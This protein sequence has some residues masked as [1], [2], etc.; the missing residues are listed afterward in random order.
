MFRTIF[1]RNHGQRQS[2]YQGSMNRRNA[3]PVRPLV[4]RLDPSWGYSNGYQTGY[5]P[6]F[7]R[8]IVDTMYDN[9]AEKP[10][11]NPM[12]YKAYVSKNDTALLE[13]HET[14][15]GHIQD[16]VSYCEANLNF[17]VVM[18]DG[19]ECLAY[20]TSEIIAVYN[21]TKNLQIQSIQYN[22]AKSGPRQPNETALA[23]CW[24]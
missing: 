23:P 7:D 16:W 14:E 22:K 18:T 2:S 12:L 6:A 8:G 21:D 24:R 4:P 15:V 9:A 17:Y 13:R 5:R 20:K 19:G 3:A 11:R 10:F 1:P